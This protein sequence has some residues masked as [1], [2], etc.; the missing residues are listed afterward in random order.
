MKVKKLSKFQLFIIRLGIRIRYITAVYDR[1][2]KRII[3]GFGLYQLGVGCVLW[4]DRWK[5]FQ[6][7]LRQYKGPKKRFI[8]VER[9]DNGDWWFHPRNG[10]FRTKRG[11]EKGFKRSFWWDLNR[12]HKILKIPHKFPVGY[13]GEWNSWYSRD[14][15]TFTQDKME[16]KHSII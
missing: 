1:F 5:D 16:Y 13:N 9:H 4:C 14:C 7:M 8:F 11:A 12:P 6:R 3:I 15:V 10:Y 2:Q